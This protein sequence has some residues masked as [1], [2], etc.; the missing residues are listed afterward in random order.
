MKRACDAV[1][2][3]ST[4]FLIRRTIKIMKLNNKV[5]II[6]GASKVIA[7]GIV[8]KLAE[9]GATVVI[10]Y[11]SDSAGAIASLTME[12]GLLQRAALISPGCFRCGD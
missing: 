7:A 10:N 3:A 8:R 11:V 5:A 9:E 12:E 6:T 4:I 1:A 2:V